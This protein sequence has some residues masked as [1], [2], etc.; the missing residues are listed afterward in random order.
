MLVG[1]K[2]VQCEAHQIASCGFASGIA[3]NLSVTTPDGHI[4]QMCIDDETYVWTATK[5]DIVA[6]GLAMALLRTDIPQPPMPWDRGAILK[7]SPSAPEQRPLGTA[8]RYRFEDTT[9]YKNN[10]FHRFHGDAFLYHGAGADPEY[11]ANVFWV[12]TRHQGDVVLNIGTSNYFL[13]PN[14]AAALCIALSNACYS[15]TKRSWNI[16]N[17][18]IDW[19]PD[20]EI[21][22]SV[23]LRAKL[24]NGLKR[25]KFIKQSY[26]PPCDI[27]SI[28]F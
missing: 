17:K 23:E 7:V 4:I 26:Q 6:Q 1:Q 15:L 24:L 3:Q 18:R 19:S 8:T 13:S 14:Q 10:R 2:N 5:A 12:K 27:D 16:L 20:G 28:E 11:P 21:S 9:G 25:Y 22:E